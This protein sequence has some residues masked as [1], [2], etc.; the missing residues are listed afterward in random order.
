MADKTLKLDEPEPK[1]P[2]LPM[3][4]EERVTELE[5]ML[6]AHEEAIRKWK[7]CHKLYKDLNTD[8]IAENELL[9]SR[10]ASL[11]CSASTKRHSPRAVLETARILLHSSNVS[12][13]YTAL[14]ER[15]RFGLQLSS[16]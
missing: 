1:E 3:S 10:V 4:L 6:T 15:D 2:K 12:E 9:H 7:E 5:K 13:G 8:L 14:W 11:E 16:Q